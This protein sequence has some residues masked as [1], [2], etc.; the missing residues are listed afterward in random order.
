MSDPSVQARRAV[1]GLEPRPARAMSARGI[2]I[3]IAIY[4]VLFGAAALH[5]WL[6]G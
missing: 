2:A 3:V 5:W 4:V 1:H 6:A